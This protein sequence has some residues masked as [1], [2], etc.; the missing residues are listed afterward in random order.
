MD[1]MMLQFRHSGPAPKLDE[2]RRMFALEAGEIDTDFGVIATDPTAG[3]Y[4]VLVA[5]SAAARVAA[6]LATRPADPA[7]GWFGNPRVEPFGSPEP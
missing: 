5:A 7:E 2:V 4:T 6:A 3:L 1:T